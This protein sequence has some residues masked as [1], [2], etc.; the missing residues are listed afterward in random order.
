[1]IL[2]L[3]KVKIHSSFVRNIQHLIP[4]T[5]RVYAA[6]PVAETGTVLQGGRL[7]GELYPLRAFGDARYKWPTDIQDRVLRPFGEVPPVGI[8]TP[9]YLNAEPEVCLLIIFLT[10]LIFCL[11]KC[12]LQVLYHRLT[13][14]DQFLVLASDGLW[15]WLDP[16]TVV[17]L[18]F[19]HQLGAQ[20]LTPYQPPQGSFLSQVWFLT[21]FNFSY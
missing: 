17:R 2:G 5:K 18:V 15:E 4:Q 19:D 9:P 11:Q 16:D 8:R 14:N 1:M 20:T 7:F 13:S 3:F 10:K 6:H 21:Y 12:Q